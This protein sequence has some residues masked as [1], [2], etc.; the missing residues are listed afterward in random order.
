[1]NLK[2]LEA[3]VLIANNKSFSMTAKELYL[4]QPTVSAYIST[5]EYELGEKLFYRTTKDV[6]LTEAGKKIYIYAKDM[7]ELA[8]KIENAFKDE[9]EKGQRQMVISASSIPGAYLLPGILAEFSRSFP[10]VEMRIHETD[11]MGVINDIREHRVDLGFVGTSTREKEVDFLPFCRYELVRVTPDT[12][13]FQELRE[14]KLDLSWIEQESWLMREDGSGTYKETLNLLD[15]M[16]IHSEKL[17][18]L[19]RFNNT[20]AILLSIKEGSG[21]SIVSRLAAQAAIDRGDILDHSLGDEGA[22]RWIC[23]ATSSVYPLSDTTKKIIKL[24]KKMYSC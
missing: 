4:T 24:I 10:N 13:R 9:S 8:E 18:V 5:L 20:G 6:S 1:M 12:E 17:R 23:V 3:F 19:A 15:N 16:G 14:K 2:Q 21:I 7:I 22:F 11:S